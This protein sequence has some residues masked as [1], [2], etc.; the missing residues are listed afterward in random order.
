[1]AKNTLYV[2]Y[3]SNLNVMQMGQ[4]CPDAEVY[5]VGR[6][7][8]Y[9]L[10]FKALGEYAYATIEP[11][12]DEYVPVAVWSISVRDEFRLDRYEGYPTHYTKQTIEVI[13]SDG[14]II[15]GMVYIMNTNAVSKVPTRSYFDCVL[16]GYGNF[17]LDVQKLYQAWL[18]ADGG[19][20]RGSSTLK[21]Y[22]ERRG[23]T[24][25]QLAKRAKVGLGSIQK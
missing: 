11:C 17:E 6:I 1:M 16:I 25:A 13:L 18:L 9:R 20:D 8:G 22:R 12:K 23:L 19:S 21:Y 4:R 14:S 5:G 7:E 2:A 3:G 10:V 15:E 24:Q